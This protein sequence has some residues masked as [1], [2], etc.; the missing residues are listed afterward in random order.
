MMSQTVNKL[1]EAKNTM[2]ARRQELERDAA[3]FKENIASIS[4]INGMNNG[5]AMIDEQY[6]MINSHSASKSS[7]GGLYSSAPNTFRPNVQAL[8]QA[9]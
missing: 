5:S 2:K 7:G 3:S 4:G 9:D 8:Q 1:S 6:E